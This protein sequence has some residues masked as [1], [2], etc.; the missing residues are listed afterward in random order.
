VESHRIVRSRGSHIFSR[1]WA[2]RWRW[3]CQVLRAGR[4]LTPGRFL[5]LIS[6]RRSVDP[7]AIVWLEGLGKLKIQLPHRESNPRP[8][9]LKHSASTNY[10]TAWPH[11][12][13]V[14]FRKILLDPLD[15]F[16]HM[17]LCGPYSVLGPCLLFTSCVAIDLWN[18]IIN[19]Y[20]CSLVQNKHIYG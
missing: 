15:C 20:V 5:V 13:D 10:A 8:S 17:G 6:V 9:G 11:T 7:R 12:N 16:Q 19:M 1:Q 2:H 18:K 14:T 4:P 3:G